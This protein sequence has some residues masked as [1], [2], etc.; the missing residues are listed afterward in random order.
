MTEAKQPVALD[1][2]PT[3]RMLVRKRAPGAT[4]G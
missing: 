1:E 2:A 3:R 4:A